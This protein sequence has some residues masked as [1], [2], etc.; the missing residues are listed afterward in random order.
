MQ[1]EMLMWHLSGFASGRNAA[2]TA[3]QHYT[4]HG[5]YLAPECIL[6]QTITKSNTVR[7][8]VSIAD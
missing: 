1:H 6:Q 8:L 2:R 7:F 4:T 5:A 3:Q